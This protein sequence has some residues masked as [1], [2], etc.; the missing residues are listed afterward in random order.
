MCTDSLWSPSDN[1]EKVRKGCLEIDWDDDQNSEQVKENVHLLLRG[2][3][4]K[5][6][7]NTKI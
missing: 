2:C 5:K 1:G 6:G 3:G 4:C 7:C